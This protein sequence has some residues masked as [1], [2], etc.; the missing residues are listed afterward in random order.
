MAALKENVRQ[1]SFVVHT[2]KAEWTHLL[3]EEELRQFTIIDK[4]DRG[5]MVQRQRLPARKNSMMTDHAWQS[6]PD[7]NSARFPGLH[8]ENGHGP[9]DINDVASSSPII[10]GPI[11]SSK[12]VILS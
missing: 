12:N 5:S 2:R 7:R 11:L 10:I 8:L 4:L 3:T 1:D 6:K 9:F